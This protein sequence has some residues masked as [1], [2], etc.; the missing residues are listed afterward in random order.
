MEVSTIPMEELAE[1]LSLQMA[2]GGTARLVV[3][4]DSMYPTFRHRKDVVFLQPVSRALK[5]GDL[6]LYKRENGQYVLHRIVT[7]PKNGAFICCGDNQ[8]EKEPVKAHQ[9]IAVT[10]GFI[11]KG[12][13]GN[14]SD[15]SYRL[16]V[17]LWIFLFPVRRPLLAL[18]RKLGRLRRK[19]T[20]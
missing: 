1:I 17:G 8:W 16:R 18:R 19:Y 5:R 2:S 6:I 13:P 20:L 15:F 10:N 14:E 7:K 11:R 9:V 4:G 12:K 3:T